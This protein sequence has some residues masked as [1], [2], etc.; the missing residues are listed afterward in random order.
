MIS[1][2]AHVNLTVP[3]DTLPQAVEFYGETLGL[4]PR[5]VPAL[6]KGN[7]AWFDIPSSSQQVQQVHIAFGTP[8][9]FENPSSRHP[10]FRVESPESLLALRKRIW[11]HFQRGGPAAPQAA[12]KPGDVD[13]GTFRELSVC[14]LCTGYVF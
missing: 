12:D 14:F 11:D 3:K 6:Q 9:D 5:P 2:L 1:G 7:L 8:S 13:S 4:T 10:C